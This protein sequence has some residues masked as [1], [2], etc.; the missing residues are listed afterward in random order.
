MNI[1]T[2]DD[3]ILYSQMPKATA[4]EIDGNTIALYRHLVGIYRAHFL[5]ETF[6]HKGNIYI[7]DNYDPKD[8]LSQKGHVFG[9]DSLDGDIIDTSQ[10]ERIK[11]G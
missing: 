9:I 4:E 7:L 2:Y 1:K 10:L 3:I 5:F 11:N 6:G 8:W